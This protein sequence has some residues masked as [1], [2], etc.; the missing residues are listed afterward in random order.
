VQ[1]V[2]G[3]VGPGADVEPGSA[4]SAFIGRLTGPLEVGPSAPEDDRHR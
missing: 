3:S 4:V 1:G 2:V